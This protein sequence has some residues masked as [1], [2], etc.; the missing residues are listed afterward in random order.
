MVNQ[1]AEGDTD[2]ATA[3]DRLNDLGHD[4]RR[5]GPERD[6]LRFFDVD[7]IGPRLDGVPRFSGVAHAYEQLGHVRSFIS[8]GAIGGWFSSCSRWLMR[9]T[10]SKLSGSHHAP[11]IVM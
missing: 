8:T 10:T 9:C 11:W 2:R 5:G 4:L 1:L 7:Q 6:G 3:G